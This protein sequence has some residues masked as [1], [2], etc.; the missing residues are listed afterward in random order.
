MESNAE[1]PEPM[2][3]RPNP[4]NALSGRELLALLDTE[5]ARLPE[6]YRLPFL[7][8]LLQGRTVEEASRLL[9]WSIGSVRGRLARGR[10]RLRRR[11]TQRGIDLSVGAV[12]L[13][14]PA[15]V[16]E[17]LLARTLHHISGPVPAAISALAGGMMPGL[18]LKILAVILILW[19]AVGL[20]AGLPLQNASEPQRPPARSPAAP[21]L[22]Q[23]NEKPRPDHFGDPL[24]A[25]AVARFGNNT[26]TTCRVGERR[27]L[28]TGRD[29]ASVGRKRRSRSGLGCEDGQG[30]AAIPSRRKRP[31]CQSGRKCGVFAGW[32]ASR[33]RRVGDAVGSLGRCQ[34]QTD[35][36]RARRQPLC[37]L[38][39]G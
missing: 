6:V 32:E 9:G 26:F 28:F 24:P 21:L 23:A 22:A 19:T 33:R 25:G 20:G 31:R 2:D 5:V 4:L 34:W 36:P 7:L 11:L 38:F 39:T 8:C 3:I 15:I 18:K 10:E 30:G 13:L 17:K 35:S 27:R 29:A 16:P 12:A 14:T 37:R 1:T